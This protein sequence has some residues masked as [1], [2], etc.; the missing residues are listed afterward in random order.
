VDSGKDPGFVQRWRDARPRKTTVVWSWVACAI[1]TMI[2]GFAWG[3]WV[4]ASTAVS[5]AE[6]KADDAVV[7]RLAPIC[8]AQFKLDP[9]KDQKLKQLKE[10][11]S[12]E[13]GDYVKKQ[14]W[15]KMPGEGGE[16][17]GKAADECAKM[18]ASMGQ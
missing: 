4:R 10:L 8:V 13:R 9:E 14:G 11:N 1:I 17:D 5:M 16:P 6:A 3:G 7:K 2:I 18:L 15:S 12:Y